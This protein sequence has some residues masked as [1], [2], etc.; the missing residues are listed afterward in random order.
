[1]MAGLGRVAGIGVV[2]ALV[3]GGGTLVGMQAGAPER[4]RGAA[5]RAEVLAL[6]GRR[7]GGGEFS[8]RGLAGAP[9]VL[10][11]YR[12]A[13]CPLCL[14]RLEALV[15]NA[16]AYDRAGARVVAITLDTPEVAAET[17]RHFGGDL[18]IVSVDEAVLRRWGVWPE[19]APAPL[20]AEF[21]L[22]PDGAVIHAHH[23]R[24]AAEDAGD[25]RLL[26]VLRDWRARQDEPGQ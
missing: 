3:A 21:V 10:V 24:S 12:G 22:G 20:P 11:F 9:A 25:V 26:G 5:V 6:E 2:L 4:E 18:E 16:A 17:A 13:Y 8:L 7:A 23:G 15:A 19:G 1:M 14:R